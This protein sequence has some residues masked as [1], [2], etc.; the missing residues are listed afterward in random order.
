MGKKAR[1]R[2]ARATWTDDEINP[3]SD[4]RLPE[5]SGP[6]GFGDPSLVDQLKMDRRRLSTLNKLV[7]TESERDVSND[8]THSLG[9]LDNIISPRPLLNTFIFEV[10]NLLRQHRGGGSEVWWRL[11]TGGS[12]ALV[13]SPVGF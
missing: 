12:E 4:T 5:R 8:A 2:A 10:V 3:K 13:T 6:I 7:S 9:E 11:V 1:N